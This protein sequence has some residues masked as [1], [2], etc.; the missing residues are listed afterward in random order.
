MAKERFTLLPFVFWASDSAKAST[1][2]TE[3]EQG[4][5]FRVKQKIEIQKPHFLK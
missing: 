4:L 3:G 5:R 2:R 1:D